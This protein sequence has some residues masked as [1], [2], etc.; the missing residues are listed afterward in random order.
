MPPIDLNL[1][2]VLDAIHKE[3]G[4][5][6]AA[7][8]LNL[9]QPAVTHALNRLRAAFD[10]PLFIRQ[11]NHVIPTERTQAIIGEV[12]RHLRGLQGT[13]RIQAAFDP[14]RWEASLVVGIR[15]MLE[16]IALPHLA[17]TLAREAP[18]LRLLSRRVAFGDLAREL[19]SGAIDLAIDRRLPPHPH[20]REAHLIDDDLVVVLRDGHPVEGALTRAAY[21]AAGHVSVSP[22]GE[23]STI[24]LLLRSNGRERRIAIVC[25]HYF[26][27]GQIAAS[28]ELMLT[29]PH[30]YARWLQRLLPI[31][32]Q[33]LPLRIRPY[34]VLA[35]WHESHDGDVALAW[36]RDRLAEAVRATAGSSPVSPMRRTGP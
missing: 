30:S 20:L 31:T 24:D 12:Q 27:A 15:D 32:V 29:L 22:L 14:A 3:G 13:I 4:I 9:T 17:G 18:R 11:G 5:T 2:R 8:A 35:Y 19:T 26:A 23:P 25:Q 7:R 10:D 28:G 21:L 33:A 6:A 16:S 1:F 36:L 34:P